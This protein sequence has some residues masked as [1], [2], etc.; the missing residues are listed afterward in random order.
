[1]ENYQTYS[2]FSKASYHSEQIM[3]S[4]QPP[5]TKLTYKTGCLLQYLLKSILCFSRP[6]LLFRIITSTAL[7]DTN[8]KCL[9]T[10]SWDPCWKWQHL[11]VS[12]PEMPATISK[13]SVGNLK[14]LQGGHSCWG[15]SMA[16]W[17]ALPHLSI[18]CQM[19]ADM[20]VLF[21]YLKSKG[22]E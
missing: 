2:V 16:E 5:R 17:G 6:L 19:P 3:T 9:S 8:F 14:M 15:H 12:D 10:W 1:M 22:R 21:P 20:G 18:L 7:H 11:S 13:S 4:W